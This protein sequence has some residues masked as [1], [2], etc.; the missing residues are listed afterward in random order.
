MAGASPVHADQGVV[1]PSR[2]WATQPHARARPGAPG[3]RCDRGV[4]HRSRSRRAW[5]RR[6]RTG[7]SSPVRSAASRVITVRASRAAPSCSLGLTRSGLRQRASGAGRRGTQVLDVADHVDAAALDPVDPQLA[8]G[9]G[10]VE[11]VG[12]QADR[13]RVAADQH[14]LGEELADEAVVGRVAPHRQ[15][16][17]A[18]EPPQQLG[19]GD[20]EAAVGPLGVERRPR[21]VDAEGAAEAEP[22][23]VAGRAAVVRHGDDVHPLGG[24]L[25]A[26]AGQHG[27]QVHRA[28]EPRLAALDLGE[29]AVEGPLAAL[30]DALLPGGGQLA[31]EVA[32]GVDD[33]DL[34]ALEVVHDPGDLVRLGRGEDLVADDDGAA[35]RG[36]PA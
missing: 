26:P 6:R 18:V 9:L 16:E 17:A 29:E 8:L 12:G 10:E 11:A 30:L 2:R 14:L 7:V 23:L 15:L 13:D 1:P 31:A 5:W 28:A 21:G 34:A 19:L 24:Q 36:V 32:R 25:G 33:V 4:A 35:R 3:G 22:Q 20:A 27:R